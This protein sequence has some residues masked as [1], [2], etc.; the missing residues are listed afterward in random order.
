M[1][2]ALI[3]LAL[4]ALVAARACGRVAGGV[5]AGDRGLDVEPRGAAG[6]CAGGVGGVDGGEAVRGRRSN[7]VL[8]FVEKNLATAVPVG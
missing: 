8:G 2:R 1:K 3:I 7:P 6:E 4:V 5:A